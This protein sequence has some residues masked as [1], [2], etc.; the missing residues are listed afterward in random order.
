MAKNAATMRLAMP[1]VGASPG[2]VSESSRALGSIPQYSARKTLLVWAAAAIPM[3]ILGWV[4]APALALDP[5]R[6][7]FE[8][9][10]V[11]TAGLIWQF[12]LVMLLVYQEAGNLRWSTIR[13]RLWLTTPR[14][15]RTAVSRRRLW[16]WLLPVILLTA[17]LELQLRGIIDHLWVTLFPFFREPDS[18]A[19]GSLLDSPEARAQ[20]VGAWH[21]WGLFVVSALFNT[22]VGEELLFR[23]LLLPRMA[24]AFGKRDW[25]VNGLLFGLYHLHQPWAILD[26]AIQG[27]LLLALPSRK[28][29]SAWFGI[30]AHSGQSVYFAILILGL[31][32]GL[33]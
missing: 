26:S 18:F 13:R 8:R 33:A 11:L 25:V 5:H 19:L 29:R 12:L 1:V 6:P 2:A 3:A 10:A 9:L 17:L 20:L 7:G 21:I 31:V 4:V 24:R 22:F 14:G 23:G 15:P 28:F 30:I 16:W 27:M 32:L